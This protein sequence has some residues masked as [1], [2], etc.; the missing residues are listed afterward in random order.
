MNTRR[1]FILKLA[2]SAAAPLALASRVCGQAPPPPAKLE[3]TDPMAMAL[4]YKEDSTKADG[5]KYPNHKPEQICSGCVLYQGKPG[6]A[7]GPC[8]AVGGKIVMAAGWCSIYA[9][10]PEPAK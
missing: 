5:A 6:E 4:G 3:E 10:K 7:N 9:K 2:V 1:N 8:G